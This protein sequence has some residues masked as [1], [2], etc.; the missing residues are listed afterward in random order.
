MRFLLIFVLFTSLAFAGE[1][2]DI[3][4][5]P[6]NE[7][8]HAAVGPE[9]PK[10]QK[11]VMLCPEIQ[12]HTEARVPMRNHRYEYFNSILAAA[13]VYENDS[14]EVMEEKIRRMWDQLSDGLLCTDSYFEVPRGNI[15]KYGVSM[16]FDRFLRDITRW[17]VDLNMVDESDGRTALDYVRDMIAKHKGN[18]HEAKLQMYYNQL[19]KAGAK[20]RSEL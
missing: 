10:K 9:C 11:L 5:K 19:R 17:G 1:G 16:N 13:C 4:A 7:A 20:H 12:A 3:P 15:I 14:K 18:T 6:P 2:P 8:D